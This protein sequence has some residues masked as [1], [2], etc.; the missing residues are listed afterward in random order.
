MRDRLGAAFEAG[1]EHGEI[2]M[3]AAKVGLRIG[4]AAIERDGEVHLLVVLGR[5]AE[6]VP[7]IGEGRVAGHRDL[8]G[9]LR[10]GRAALRIEDVAEIEGEHRI[11][12]IGAER[13][14][15]EPFGR[16]E[17]AAS[18]PPPRPRARRSSTVRASAPIGMVSWPLNSASWPSISR[19]SWPFGVSTSLASASVVPRRPSA[20]R[21]IE[22]ARDV[23]A[24]G[25]KLA[26][27][28]R[29]D[30]VAIGEEVVDRLQ[31][32]EERQA[33]DEPRIEP[34]NALDLARRKRPAD[35]GRRAGEAE[36]ALQRQ[37]A[38]Q[39]RI[40]GKRRRQPDT[41]VG[42]RPCPWRNGRARSA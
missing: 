5:E 8:P 42:Q 39:R 7:G 32:V 21:R 19:K 38:D 12:G 26:G 15:I 11:V 3:G 1:E 33:G 6:I 16:G 14:R 37:L 40:V 30:E 9:D 23:D 31:H 13:R 29:R 24:A 27:L 4:G 41:A 2:E 22:D 25:E 17:V 35:I 18:P 36:P 10:L 34:G 20:E 28:P